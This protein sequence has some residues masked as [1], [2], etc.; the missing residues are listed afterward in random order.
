MDYRA[1]FEK[2]VKHIKTDRPPLDLNGTPLTSYHEEFLKAF[3]K[4]H[5]MDALDVA[6][7]EEKIMRHYDIDFRRVG[8]IFKPPT[9]L[10]DNSKMSQ[11]EFTN[12]WG[13]KWQLFG[14]YWEIV[15]NPLKDATFEEIKAFPWPD[16]KDIDR[17]LIREETEKAKRLYYDTDYVVVAGHPVYGYFELGC[18]MFGFD[19]FL[20]RIAAE[21][22]TAEWFFE[23]YHRYVTD[24]NELYYGSLGKY[25]HVTT[26]GDDFG[27]QNGPFISPDMFEEMVAPWYKKRIGQ[28]KSMC[29]ALFFHHSCGSVYK[30]LPHIIDMGV[31]ILNP[32]QPG[33]AD[34]EP[35]KLKGEFG[36]K[37]VFWG[38]IDEQNLLSKATVE[39]VKKEVRRVSDILSEN[40]GYILASS[41]N[42][43]PDVPVENIDAMLTVFR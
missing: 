15:H 39:E 17:N 25:I 7:A 28:V 35:E 24:V 1:R 8:Y 33:T 19:D 14:L 12:C 20:Y 16:A 29:N 31:D 32:I 37:L 22:E 41:H 36:D 3:I 18:W 5:N 26:S 11:G 9:V 6:D 30:L 40:G 34:M 23:N 42:V 10:T 2:T 27:M 43:Q 38:G 13:I 4:Y 21:P